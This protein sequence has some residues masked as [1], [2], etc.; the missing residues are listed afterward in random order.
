MASST[1]NLKMCKQDQRSLFDLRLLK[2]PWRLVDMDDFVGV[3]QVEALLHVQEV[4]DSDLHLRYPCIE[5]DRVLEYN[6][7]MA[8]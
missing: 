4:T 6:H 3:E 1:R 8:S 5:Y 2:E 7:F